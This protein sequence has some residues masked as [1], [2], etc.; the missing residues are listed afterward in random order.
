MLA[1]RNVRTEFALAHTTHGELGFPC[2]LAGVS[3]L[4]LAS[5][6]RC[7][8]HR[9]EVKPVP[10][11]HKAAQTSVPLTPTSATSPAAIPADASAWLALA[12]PQ[13]RLGA[14]LSGLTAE[15]LARFIAGKAAFS[16]IA[17]PEDGQGPIFNLHS[18]LGCHSNPVGGSG[19][20]TI[21]LFGR[22]VGDKFDGYEDAGGPMLQTESLQPPCAE[23]IPLDATV[24]AHRLTP[25]LMGA[26]LVEAIADEAILNLADRQPPGVHG[27]VQWVTSLE[28][29]AGSP[30]RVGR[31]GFKAQLSATVLTC[32]AISTVAEIG[33]TNR[34]VPEEFAPNGDAARVAPCDAIPDPEIR[35]D[36]SG[37]DDIDRITDFQ[38]YLAPPPQTPRSGMTGE[39]VF[40]RIGCADCH[41]PAFV[42][43]DDPALEPAL[44]G[45]TIHPYGDYLLHNMG[46]NADGIAQ[47][48]AGQWDMRTMPLWGFRIRFPVFHDG[49]VAGATV[50]ERAQRT[51]EL[52]GGE[53]EESVWS[54]HALSEKEHAQLIAFLDSL[55]RV[56]FDHDGDNDVDLDDYRFFDS[57]A[58]PP[59][60]RAY[61]P[62]ERCAIA[63]IDQDG[64]VDLVDYSLLQ[65]VFTGLE[66]GSAMVVP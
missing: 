61:T 26:G 15:Q 22:V 33:M 9:A 48:E 49:R 55:G 36:A 31:F 28:A 23:E 59:G 45:R 54:Y 52:H 29:P 14:P 64:D 16:R 25:S 51:I 11:D 19:T 7:T 46:A 6:S 24:I 40:R 12:D 57:C 60:E 50:T 2:S 20:S 65:R 1:A 4:V 53:A 32:S 30:L 8:L 63:D 62:E 43:S 66:Y 34:L 18:C 35:P 41:V 39:A 3:L 38:R 56:E 13:P 17:R 21:T 58:G 5:L 42:T 27:H 44:R 10:V 37:R 47:G